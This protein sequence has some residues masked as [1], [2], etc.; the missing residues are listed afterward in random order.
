MSRK[1]PAVAF[2]NHLIKT[3]GR[4]DMLT[5]LQA[6]PLRQKD[7]NLLLDYIEGATYKELAAKYAKS[8]QRIYQWKRKIYENLHFYLT[9]NR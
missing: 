4:N 3:T 2:I 1:T 8:E 7:I 5:I 6:S 9:Q